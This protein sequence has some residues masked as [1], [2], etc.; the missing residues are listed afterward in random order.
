MKEL[1]ASVGYLYIHGHF[2]RVMNLLEGLILNQNENFRK[3]RTGE[4]IFNFGTKLNFT[5][6][7]LKN[8][9]IPK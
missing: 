6:R 5:V 7:R 4:K 3:W 9:V 8:F 1:A 2:I